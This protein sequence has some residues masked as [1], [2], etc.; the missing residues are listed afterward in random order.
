[1]TPR[2]LRTPDERFADLD[3]YPFEPHFAEVNNL[4]LHY[5]DEGSGRPVVLFHGEPTWSYLYRKIIPILSAAGYRAI[6]PDYVGFGKSDKPVDP[7]FYTYDTHVA[8]MASLL[9]DLSLNGATSVVQDWGGPIGLRLTVEHPEW[10][11]R[12]VVMNTGLFSGGAMGAAF[13]KWRDFVERTPDLPIRFIMERSMVTSWP[14]GALAGY[15]APFPDQAHKVGAYRFPLIVP[16]SPSDRGAATME[17]IKLQLT[18]WDNPSLVLFSTEDPIFTVRV[19]ERWVDRL[20]GAGPLEL[21][22][23]AGH[24]L[25][26]DQGEA[27]A[28]R[29]VAFLK[30]TD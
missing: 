29:I 24:F 12:L 6:A 8:L 15:D 17:R 11:D 7:A 27:V 28:E 16:L 1:M 18:E 9:D 2:I 20:P 3:G 26:E 4:R 21:V 5:L 30:R 10:F 23:N 13:M 19:G 22:E 14:D 25:Q